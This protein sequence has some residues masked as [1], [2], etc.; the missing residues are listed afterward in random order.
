MFP[1][2]LSLRLVEAFL[3]RWV[4]SLSTLRQTSSSIP[5]QFQTCLSKVMRFPDH[6]LQPLL[7]GPGVAKVHFLAKYAVNISSHGAMRRNEARLTP[8]DVG[9]RHPQPHLLRLLVVLRNALVL[10]E[11]FISHWNFFYKN[12]WPEFQPSL[13]RGLL[14]PPLAVLVGGGFWVLSTFGKKV[15]TAP[16]ERIIQP[17]WI[18]EAVAYAPEPTA[19]A[20]A[21]PAPDRSAE[22]LTSS[23]RSRPTCRSSGT[24]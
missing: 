12:T 24:S 4:H 20:K 19:A 13:P 2:R 18:T 22:I 10:C 7:L 3:Q 21:A 1:D 14:L 16:V 11:K 15:V 23:P 6:A 9:E 8:L 5:P 17:S